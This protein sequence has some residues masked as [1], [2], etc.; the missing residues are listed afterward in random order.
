MKSKDRKAN[1]KR[2]KEFRFHK[3]RIENSKKKIIRH[4]AYIFMEKGNVY[5]FVT[6]THSN[7]VGDYLV[8]KLRQNPDPT[9][10]RDSYYVAEIQTDTK[11][12]FSKNKAN[13]KMNELDDQDIR[14]LFDSKRKDD[15]ADRD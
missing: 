13:W 14:K 15:S 12:A 8:I 2:K 3:T 9:D 7:K 10:S 4:P 11:D 5:I 6:L 1:P